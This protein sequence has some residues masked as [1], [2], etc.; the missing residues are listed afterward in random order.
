LHGDMDQRARMAMLQGFRDGKLKLLVA[1]DVAARGL[2]IP[3][4]SHVFNYNLPIHSEDYVHRIGR[5]GRAGRS[6]KAF[7]LVARPDR[8]FLDAIEKMIGRELEWLDGD[9]STLG[10]ESPDESRPSRGRGGKG[11]DRERGRSRDGRRERKPRSNDVAA[12]E[13]ETVEAVEAT[14]PEPVAKPAR[15]RRAEAG[16][17]AQA[18]S[19]RSHPAND[20]GERR[21]DA[22]R[23]PR[24]ERNEPADS[25]VG[26]GDEVPAFMNILVR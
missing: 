5:T 4:V 2:D 10:E 18:P 20:A 21:N 24:R 7:S 19:P 15:G 22:N 25:V 16:T 6:G 3:D 26:F 12:E 13:T 17:E 8:K 1:S 23:R 11:S 9:L 14:A